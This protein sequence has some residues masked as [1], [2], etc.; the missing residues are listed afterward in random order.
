MPFAKSA[1]ATPASLCALAAALG[2]SKIMQ[3]IKFK[4]G[5]EEVEAIHDEAAADGYVYTVEASGNPKEKRM[6]QVFPRMLSGVTGDTFPDNCD[7]YIYDARSGFGKICMIYVHKL[8]TLC[9]AQLVVSFNYMDW[10]LSEALGSFVDRY[11]AGI[12]HAY[13]ASEVSTSKSEYGYD[14]SWSLP[15]QADED[16]HRIIMSMEELLESKYRK[17]LIP[18]KE[19][20][21]QYGEGRLHWWIRYVVIP[22]ACSGTI[23]AVIGKYLLK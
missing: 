12:R 17:L 6:Q 5:K 23:A 22:L 7:L 3:R 18:P 11:V 19:N 21:T 15:I 8:Q 20:A 13:P 16:I 4:I 10:D 9:R 14:V 1:N 2:D